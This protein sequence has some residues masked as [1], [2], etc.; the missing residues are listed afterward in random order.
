MD[1]SVAG[2]KFLVHLDYHIELRTPCPSPP[3]DAYSFTSET[4]SGASWFTANSK[5]NGLGATIAAT[6]EIV[7]NE[8]GNYSAT[9]SGV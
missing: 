6:D 1:S 7:I 8:A 4:T 2:D 9:F 3:V 5:T